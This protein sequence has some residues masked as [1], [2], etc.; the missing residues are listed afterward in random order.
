[1]AAAEPERREPERFAMAVR[2]KPRYAR[3]RDF[4]LTQREAMASQRRRQAGLSLIG[5]LLF[6]ILAAVVVLQT[7]GANAGSRRAETA[8]ADIEITPQPN[9]HVDPAPTGPR[10][11]AEAD[12]GLATNFAPPRPVCVRLCDGFFF[13]SSQ[14]AGVGDAGDEADA[15][16]GLCPDAPTALFYQPASSDRIEDAV[17][18]SGE[19]YSA[20][21]AALRYRAVQDA[22]CACRRSTADAYNPM[23]DATLRKGDAV[24]TEGGL[25]VFSGA[26][27]SEHAQSDFT[28]IAVAKLPEARRATLQALE[29]V[30][31]ATRSAVQESWQADAEPPRKPATSDGIRFVER[32]EAGAE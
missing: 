30:S 17:S 32:G 22:T 11:S 18:A 24:M 29:T 31:R 28:T 5:A 26:E 1:M 19:S 20:L 23:R 8:F 7:V 25:I 21:P 9:V 15:C 13:P 16:A 4:G 2:V 14:P 3:P 6:G 27:A 10:P 12:M